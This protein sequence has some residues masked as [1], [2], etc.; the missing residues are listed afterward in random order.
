MSRIQGTTV[1]I[2]GGASGIGRLMGQEVLRRGAK[3][4]ILWDLN[5]AA[6]DEALTQFRQQGFSVE[7]YV[8]D[9]AD[10]AGVRATFGR[11]RQ[12]SAAID[13]L[14][15]NAGIIVGKNFSEHSHEEIDRTLQI[16]TAALMHLARLSLPDMLEQKAGHLV[17]IASAAGMLSNP[18]MS[19]YC[20]SK[21]AVIGWS[22]SLR[23]EL[24]RSRSGVRVTT[25]TPYYI[26]TGMFSGVRSPIIP[27]LKPEATAR[28]I[29]RAIEKDK[30]FL[31][32]PG[33]LH[34]LPLV[35][36]ILPVRCFDRLFGDWLGIYK[37][38][39]F[40]RGRK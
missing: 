22:D 12:R 21:W 19:V 2:T 37:T 10:S 29:I 39:K 23:L 17:N 15:N 16:N 27:I 3:Q 8:V 24:E 38:M 9:L 4:L 7:G 20:G 11:M 5:G 36:G 32:L 28:A 18:Q 31:R 30:I 6:L 14:I 26:D 25:V 13:I 1:L 34:L 33:I 40:F 35:K